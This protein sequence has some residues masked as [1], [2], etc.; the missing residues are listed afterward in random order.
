M[1][2]FSGRI[3]PTIRRMPSSRRDADQP[4]EQLGAEP[5]PLE[6]V[7]DQQG[8]LGVAGAAELAQPADAQDLVPAV[9]DGRRSLGH[10]GHLAVVVDEADARQ[11]LVRHPRAQSFIA[12]K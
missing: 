7:G 9:G 5:A 2:W 11:P 3:E 1:P 8:E 6:S 12:W 4:S 10:Q